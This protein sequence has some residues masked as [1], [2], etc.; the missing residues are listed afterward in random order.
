MQQQSTF[1]GNTGVVKNDL[2]QDYRFF[3][4]WGDKNYLVEEINAV[5]LCEYFPELLN[6]KNLRKLSPND[7]PV[8]L[9]YKIK[10]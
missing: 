7:N 6:N 10:N 8:I 9:I 5:L 1:V 3:P 2:I 4:R